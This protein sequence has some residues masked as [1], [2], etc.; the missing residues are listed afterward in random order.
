M[1]Q[2]ELSIYDY[3]IKVVDGVAPIKTGPLTY[4]FFVVLYT[5]LEQMFNALWG[6]F[7]L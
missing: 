5:L 2:K 6:A 7:S 4:S 1:T 3:I